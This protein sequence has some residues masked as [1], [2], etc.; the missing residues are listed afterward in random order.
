MRVRFVR[1]NS[2]PSPLSDFTNTAATQPT[3]KIIESKSWVYND[4]PLPIPTTSTLE[5]PPAKW[6]DL[7]A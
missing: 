7:L 5:A 2:R 6:L 4:L 3:A 1:D